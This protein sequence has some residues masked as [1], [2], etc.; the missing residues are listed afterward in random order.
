VTAG[1]ETADAITAAAAGVELPSHPV[2]M[3]KVTVS[4]P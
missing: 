2:A 4:N 1:M 3:T